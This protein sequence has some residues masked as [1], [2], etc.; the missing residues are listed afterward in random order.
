MKRLFFALWPDQNTRQ[1]CGKIIRMTRSQGKPVAVH[2]LHVTLVFLGGVDESTQI[3]V[4][5]AASAIIVQPMHLIFNRLSYWKKPAVVCLT[6]EQF[7]PVL[8]SLVEQLTAAAV[9]NRIE[10]DP[11]PYAPH[12]TLLRKARA[13]PETE[14]TPIDWQADGFCLVESYSTPAGVEYR[15]I[16]RWGLA[17]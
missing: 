6:A 15:V 2:N 13:L 3:A 8:S 12:V 7:E 14:F 10:V 5:Q 17:G 9:R 11:R 1:Q 4:T 16:E